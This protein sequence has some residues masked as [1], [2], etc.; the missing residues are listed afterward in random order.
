MQF[1]VMKFHQQKTPAGK[2][3]WVAI[4]AVHGT[5]EEFAAKT[6]TELNALLCRARQNQ[7]Q[8]AAEAA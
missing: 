5:V 2:S 4:V 8:Q 3:I 7:I 6:T 1:S